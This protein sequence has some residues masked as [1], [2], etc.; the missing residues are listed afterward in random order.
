MGHRAR[1]PISG[2]RGDSAPWWMPP[3]VGDDRTMVAWP[4]SHSPSPSP[5]PARWSAGSTRTTH[6]RRCRGGPHR[7][8]PRDRVVPSDPSRVSLVARRGCA[9]TGEATAIPK[10]GDGPVEALRQLRVARAGDEGPGSER[11]STLSLWSIGARGAGSPRG[12]VCPLPAGKARTPLCA[13]GAASL[14]AAA[15]PVGAAAAP[16]LRRACPPHWAAPLP[17]WPTDDETATASAVPATYSRAVAVALRHEER[18]VRRGPERRACCQEN[19]HR[20]SH[21]A[22]PI[23]CTP[24]STLPP[25]PSAPVAATQLQGQD[26]HRRTLVGP[27]PA[28]PSTPSTSSPHSSSLDTA[29]AT[30]PPATPRRYASAASAGPVSVIAG[31]VAQVPPAG[32]RGC[33]RLRALDGP[34]RRRAA[35]TTVGVRL[36]PP[37]WTHTG[38]RIPATAAGYE[39]YRCSEPAQGSATR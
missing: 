19:S 8:C 20:L 33:L 32:R 24:S 27:E 13:G 38:A 26:R 36:G 6:P 39:Q 21:R 23:N 12:W 37:R 15:G 22:V 3:V 2:R 14:G 1:R 10:T 29:S 7:E 25:K 30:R 28:T 18:H 35:T 17:L 34:H 31:P 9:A 16:A 4:Q 5:S 11:A